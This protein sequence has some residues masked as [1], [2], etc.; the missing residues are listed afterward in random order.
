MEK[1]FDRISNYG[2]YSEK[3][4]AVIHKQSNLNL[5]GDVAPFGVP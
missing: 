4:E 2:T 5:N 3:V 1:K